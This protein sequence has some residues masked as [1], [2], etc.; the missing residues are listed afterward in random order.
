MM[1]LPR[2]SGY[3]NLPPPLRPLTKRPLS[4]S[5]TLALRYL[6]HR[7]LH[8]RCIRI[9]EKR[10]RLNIQLHHQRTNLL[11]LSR[12]AGWIAQWILSHHLHLDLVS[13]WRSRSRCGRCRK[14]RLWNHGSLIII[15][16]MR[17]HQVWGVHRCL[18]L[19]LR[20]SMIVISCSNNTSTGGMMLGLFRDL[21]RRVNRPR[22]N[23]T[24]R[25][26]RTCRI[27]LG[28]IIPHL[29]MIARAGNGSAKEKEKE[30]GKG[31]GNSRLTHITLSN[32]RLR[33]LIRGP[34]SIISST[35]S[36]RFSLH[37]RHLGGGLDMAPHLYHHSQCRLAK[38]RAR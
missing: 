24:Y 17:V 6:M 9:I 22:N 21:L 23:L 7:I 11:H 14:A 37:R 12:L 20:K 5:H 27:R 30:S 13:Q 29:M 28:I 10:S 1:I 35:C 8:N 18:E 32:S 38:L 19:A 26:N 3:H 34:C 16:R 2:D 15:A 33:H 36:V 31:G 25:I 4:I